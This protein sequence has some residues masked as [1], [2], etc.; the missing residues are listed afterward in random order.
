MRI[1]FL[2]QVAVVL[3]GITA[4]FDIAVWVS[5]TVLARDR[6]DPVAVLGEMVLGGGV[7]TQSLV[8]GALGAFAAACFRKSRSAMVATLIF[9]L[10]CLLIL[11]LFNTAMPPRADFDQTWR[12]GPG[13]RVLLSET[14]LRPGGHNFGYGTLVEMGG[15]PMNA[16]HEFVRKVDWTRWGGWMAIGYGLP[17]VL[18]WTYRRVSRRLAPLHAFEVVMSGD[19]KS[20]NG[21]P[22]APVGKN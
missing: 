22:I 19:G 18:I 2:I 5:I 21:L 3:V 13:P 10:C 20:K 15:G 17:L 9:A 11:A 14:Y 1:R 7:G 6:G 16:Y 4:L 8:L 12:L